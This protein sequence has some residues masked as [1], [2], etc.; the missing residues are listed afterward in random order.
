MSLFSRLVRSNLDVESADIPANLQ[1]LAAMIRSSPLGDHFESLDA[2]DA[3]KRLQDDTG[4]VGNR[5][6]QF[7]LRH[8]HRCYKE[9]D[10]YS[11][12]WIMNPLPL[13]RSIQGYVRSAT[14][15]E[16][17]E[18]I[19]L[20]AL[21]RRPGFIYKRLLNM[22]L[23]RA[24][25]AVYAREA[26]KSAVVKCIH[27]LRLALWEIGD[28]L[29]REGRLP[30]AELIFFL[31]LDEAHRL[32]Q[33]RDPNIVSRAIRRQRIHPVLNK[34]KFDVLIC[35]FPKPISEDQGDVDVNAL[36]V[37]GTTVSEGIVTGIARVINDFETEAL[38]IQ[39]GEIL[40]THATDT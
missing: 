28:S 14:D 4:T 3:L 10:F 29:R 33:D 21:E 13:I 15:V 9:F 38:L 7:M 40:I 22:F 35:G 39:R 25:M 16:K 30:E 34:Q 24:Q 8:G 37:G 12:P 26:M 2:Q 1:T 36:Y 11:R 18:R 17:T 23:P 6:R 31:T 19:T 32:A 27:E 20:D 5:F